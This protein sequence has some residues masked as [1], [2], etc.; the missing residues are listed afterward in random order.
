MKKDKLLYRLKIKKKDGTTQHSTLTKRKRLYSIYQH[1]NIS[2]FE[3]E[4]V[5]RRGVTNTG[6][7]QSREEM[8]KA[9]RSWTEPTLIKYVSEGK[10]DNGKPYSDTK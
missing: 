8:F 2:E 10:W 3:L 9:L 6:V 4:V 1:E 7:F 5:Y